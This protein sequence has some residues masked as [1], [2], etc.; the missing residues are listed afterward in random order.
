[1]L[2][3]SK[4]IDARP[5]IT[6]ALY[7]NGQLLGNHSY[8]HDQWRWLDPSYPELDRTQDAF[9]RQLGGD[10]CP[11]WFRPPHGQRTPM[12]ARVVHHNGMRMA[13]W[14]DS[15][16][17]WSMTDP[18]KIANDVLAKVHDGSIIDLHDGLDGKPW[19]D[20]SQVVKA[21]PLILDG[22][23]ARHL[24]PVRLD[25]LLGGPAYQSCAKFQS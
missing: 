24:K 7:E 20:R 14:D 4:A 3:R 18:Q 21:L 15:V 19:V 6:R 10:A 2:F 8:H 9:A 11:V 22:L 17:D 16:P 23:R 5:D 1:M 12:M 25:E 13:M